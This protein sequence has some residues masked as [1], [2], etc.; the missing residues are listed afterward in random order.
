MK[1]TTKISVSFR[2]RKKLWVDFQKTCI[3]ADLVPSQVLRAYIKSF[4]QQKV[5]NE[6][7]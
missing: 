6:T 1:P 5:Q 7:Q 2:I 3:Q 4:I